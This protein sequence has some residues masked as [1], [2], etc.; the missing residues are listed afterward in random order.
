MKLLTL[1]LLAALTGCESTQNLNDADCLPLRVPADVVLLQEAGLYRV[2]GKP[3]V[4][5]FS[6]PRDTVND[7]FNSIEQLRTLSAGTVLSIRDLTQRHGFDSGKGRIS[8]FG[9]T[10]DGDAF[11]HGWGAGT[12]IGRAPWEPASTPN[13]RPVDCSK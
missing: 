8:A 7:A 9:T 1:A 11:E 6:L 13:I 2:G 3:D 10:P 5:L 4:F 12:V